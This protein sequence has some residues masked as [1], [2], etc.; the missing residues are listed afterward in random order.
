MQNHYNLLYREEE[1]EMNP[2]CAEEGVGLIPWS[3]LARGRLA[4]PVDS[5]STQRLETDQFGKTMYAST[6]AADRKLIEKTTEIAQRKGVPQ[7]ALALAW[8]LAKPGIASPIVGATK[9]HHLTDAATALDIKLSAQEV[10][11][12]EEAYVPHP[13]LGF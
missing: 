8:M 7:A 1:R 13:V 9:P 6:E 11:E 3:P 5:E 12:L 10:K 4:R 2:L